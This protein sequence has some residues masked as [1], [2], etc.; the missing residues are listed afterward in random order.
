MRLV[1]AHIVVLELR[2][3]VI[4]QDDVRTFGVNEEVPILSTDGAIAA[5]Y[6]IASRSVTVYPMLPRWPCVGSD[7]C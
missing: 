2:F 7:G 4:Q 5:G 3:R 6:F 1:L